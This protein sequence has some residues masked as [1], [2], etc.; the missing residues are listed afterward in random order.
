MTYK[1]LMTFCRG[2]GT[3]CY[4]EM[5]GETPAAESDHQSFSQQTCNC[6]MKKKLQRIKYDVDRGGGGTV[7][8]I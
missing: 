7:G 1:K 2:T 5:D 6:K 3:G 8:Q 4:G